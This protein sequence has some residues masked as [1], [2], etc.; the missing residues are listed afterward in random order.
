LIF[1]PRLPVLK[2]RHAGGC[3]CRANGHAS[4][5]Q[6]LASDRGNACGLVGR[7]WPGS[8]VGS[9][10]AGQFGRALKVEQ[11]IG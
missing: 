5:W 9:Q 11:G 2:G 10:P 7:H 1:R 4:S 8:A 3:G 6:P